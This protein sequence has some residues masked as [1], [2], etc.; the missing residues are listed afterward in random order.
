MQTRTQNLSA[1][2]I[3]SVLCM[4]WGGLADLDALDLKNALVVSPP[5]LSGPEKKAVTMPI[6]EVEKRTHVRWPATTAW[7][8]S[9]APVIAIGDLS[10][11]DQFAGSYSKELLA[12]RKAA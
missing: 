6:E 4:L 3:A 8:S 12:V 1:P 2:I 11:L 9:N 7:P 10:N 5:N